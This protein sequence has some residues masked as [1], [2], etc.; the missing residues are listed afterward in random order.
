MENSQ[1][2]LLQQTGQAGILDE[3]GLVALGAGGDTADF[4]AN[5]LAQEVEIIA[6]AGREIAFA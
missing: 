3:D 1:E 6:G 2:L 4:D 5:A